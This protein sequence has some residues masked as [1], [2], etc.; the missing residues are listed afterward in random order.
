LPL[1]LTNRAHVFRTNHLYQGHKQNTAY[2]YNILITTPSST[3][4]VAGVCRVYN[5]ATG[6]PAYTKVKAAADDKT[7]LY[8]GIAVGVVL[9]ILVVGIAIAKANLAKAHKIL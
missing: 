1:P 2:D 4:G 5:G 3:P 7:I 8:V 9:L 6:T